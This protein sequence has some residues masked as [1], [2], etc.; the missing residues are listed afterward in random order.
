MTKDRTSRPDVPPRFFAGLLLPFAVPMVLTMALVILVGESWPRQIAPGSGLKLAG[1][2][3]SALTTILVWHRVTHGIADRRVRKMAALICGM[4]GLLGWPVWS[5]GILPSIN[6]ASLGPATTQRMV[7]ERTES[8][9]VSRSRARNHWAW[10]RS[11]DAPADRYFISEELYAR[12]NSQRP[13][14]VTVTFAPGL[15]GAEV[16]T[17]YE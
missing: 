15:L 3:A 16:V 11:G 14:T 13:E 7:L 5:I 1:L 2:G 10:L 12:W 6:G 4:V 9:P 17:G 8:T